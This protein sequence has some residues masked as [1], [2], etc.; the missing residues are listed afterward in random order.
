MH[1]TQNRITVGNTIAGNPIDIVT[2]TLAAKTAG[3]KVHIQS[4]MHGGEITYWVQHRLYNFLKEN[5]KA[6]EVV[7]VPCANPAAWE[8]RS[9]FYTFGKFDLY[10]G[11]DPNTHF[12]GKPD[13]SLHQRIVHALYTLAKN[14]DLGLDLHTARKSLPYVIFTKESYAPLVKEVGLKYNFLDDGDP[15]GSFDAGLD[16]LNIDNLCIECGSHDEYDAA[17]IEQVFQG[18]LRLLAGLGMIDRSLTAHPANDSHWFRT[19]KKILTRDA[20]FVRYDVALG[21]PFKKGDTLFT[22]HPSSELGAEQPEK[23]TEDG[24][25]YKHAPTHIYRAGDETLHYIPMDALNK[26]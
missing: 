6:G 21:T 10:D 14:C 8:Q 3:K 24:V 22:L 16:P 7:F 25:M 1:A 4:G 5:L 19:D 26:I 11:K 9:Y 18:I 20:G 13:G 23:A 2:Y 17:K 12:P 15:S